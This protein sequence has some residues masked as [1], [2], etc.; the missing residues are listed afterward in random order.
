MASP[1]ASVIVVIHSGVS[2]LD[3]AVASLAAE[4][5]RGVQ[6]VVVDNGSADGVADVARRRFPWAT[7]VR[8]ESNLGFAGGVHLGAEAADGEVLVLLNDDAAAE[9][10][11]VDAHLEALSRH[12]GAAAT[13]GRLVSW[14]RR[15]HDFVKGRVT[16]DAHAF[17]IGQ[18]LPLTEAEPPADGEPLPFACGGNMAVR[19][20]DWDRA[21]G[22]DRG[23]FAYFEDVELGWRLTATGR[24]VVAA[25]AAVARHRGSATSAG[26]GDFRRGVLFERNAL[27][28]FFACADADCRAAFGSAVLVTFLHRLAAFAATDR[29]LGWWAADPFGPA[30][31]P[32][33]RASRWKQRLRDAGPLAAMRHLATRIVGGAR[34]G[35]PTLDDGLV[36]M[37]LR[38]AR[39]FAD[40]LGATT[41]RRRSL[42]AMRTVSDRELLARFPRLVVPTYRGD[43]ELFA[44]D[45]FRDLLPDGWPLEWTDLD[46]LIAHS[47]TGGGDG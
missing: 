45:G 34:V 15:R 23:L 46:D 31:V 37:Q 8:S 5:A 7:V 25:P 12:P 19:R 9:D 39:G 29:D 32:P 40:G 1:A 41:A 33:G 20:A 14:D 43:A 6:V 24:D 38:A 26:L 21:A 22:F 30:P 16:F 27:R 17:Q 11:F 10:G 28:V 2:R 3:D 35:M 42:E 18:G 44:S 36:L 13:A 47:A 4:A